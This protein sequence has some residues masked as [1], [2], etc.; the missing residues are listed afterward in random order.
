MALLS[1]TLYSCSQLLPHHYHLRVYTTIRKQ[2]TGYSIAYKDVMTTTNKRPFMTRLRSSFNSSNNTSNN[3]SLVTSDAESSEEEYSNDGHITT[4]KR[5]K[6]PQCWGHRGV[7]NYLLPFTS[8]LCLLCHA[9]YA[10]CHAMLHARYHQV[11]L[12]IWWRD[13]PTTASRQYTRE[14]W[15]WDILDTAIWIMHNILTVILSVILHSPRLTIFLYF[16]CIPLIRHI[17]ILP[18]ILYT[19]HIQPLL[20]IYSQASAAFPE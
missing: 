11:L 18:Q 14:G 16:P 2:D 17:L 15:R 12:P 5:Q 4:P 7:S 9:C 6:L 13:L 10:R 1:V 8:Y 19:P 3:T 20:K